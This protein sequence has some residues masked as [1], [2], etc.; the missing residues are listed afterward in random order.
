MKTL[1]FVLYGNV[2]IA[3]CAFVQ[4]LQTAYILNSENTEGLLTDSVLPI[5]AAAATFFLYNLHKPIS[6]LL[7]KQLIENQ[8]F[9]KTKAFEKTSP[10]SPGEL[11]GPEC[12]PSWFENDAS[13]PTVFPSRGTAGTATKS[14]CAG[15][16]P[17]YP[18]TW[19]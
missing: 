16:A 10:R 17:A 19:R 15:F 11:R 2:L 4:T 13:Q 12:H 6:F 5:F 14:L 1:D 7:K 9:L 3:V 18:Y 8:R